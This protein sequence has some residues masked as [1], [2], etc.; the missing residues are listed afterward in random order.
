MTSFIRGRAIAALIMAITCS[1]AACSSTKETAA[2]DATQASE[3]MQSLVRDTMN[4]A[5]GQWT[6]TSNGPTA[7]PCT[8]PDG[9]EGVWFSWDQDADGVSDPEAVMQ[10]VDRAWRDHGLATTTQS[11][12]RADGETLHRVGSAGHDV[13]SIQFNATTGGM[14]INVR[15]LCGTGNVDD[16]TNDGG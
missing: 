6:S 7:D 3:Q 12:E 14:S 15:S 2:L 4:V 1:V 8:T 10:G 5:R 16:F 11:V 9:D 13:D